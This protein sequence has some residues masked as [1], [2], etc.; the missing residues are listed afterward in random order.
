MAENIVINRTFCKTD[1]ENL[2]MHGILMLSSRMHGCGLW[3]GAEQ[4]PPSPGLCDAP[5]EDTWSKSCPSLEDTSAS[6]KICV[7]NKTELHFRHWIWGGAQDLKF[8]LE[9][10]DL[11]IP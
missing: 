7:R 11:I 9:S 5:C 8:G 6:H 1:L 10:C 3:R 4:G 2:V